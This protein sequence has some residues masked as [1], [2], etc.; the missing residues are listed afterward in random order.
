MS[1]TNTHREA[2][3]V[4]GRGST[5]AWHWGL[6]ALAAMGGSGCFSP[7]PE[8]MAPAVSSSSSAAPSVTTA[9]SST[10]E[11]APSAT[12][13]PSAAVTVAPSASSHVAEK[14]APPA[15]PPAPE[16]AGFSSCEAVEVTG[17][18]PCEAI[19]KRPRKVAQANACCVDPVEVV[20]QSGTSV[21]LRVAACEFVP[22]ECAHVH[23]H[24]N[25][26]ASLRVLAGPQ[27]E[28]VVVEG[29]CEMRAIMHGYVPPGA[30]AWTGCNHQRYRWDGKNLVKQ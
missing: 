7:N 12:P 23:G 2:A 21:L 25:M 16:V 9:S 28:V 27:P 20:V 18:A 22:P 15:C 19:C 4:V 13:A 26:D 29:G 1:M 10:P 5:A 30:A 6:F 8:V 3:N 17:A 14:A 24:G 11:P